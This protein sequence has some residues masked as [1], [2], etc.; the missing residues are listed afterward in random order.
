MRHPIFDSG[1]VSSVLG[2]ELVTYMVQYIKVPD[3]TSPLE[4][5]L[6]DMLG[7]IESL[8]KRNVLSTFPQIYGPLNNYDGVLPVKIEPPATLCTLTSDQ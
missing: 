7:L 4:K 3:F 1:F 6:K 2:P 5:S 8:N